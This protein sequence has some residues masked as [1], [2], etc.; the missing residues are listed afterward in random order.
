[1]SRGGLGGE[2]PARVGAAVCGEGA[3]GGDHV[4][5]PRAHGVQGAG[6]P[7]APIRTRSA[8][9][10]ALQGMAVRVVRGGD[11]GYRRGRGGMFVYT[12]VPSDSSFL[13]VSVGSGVPFAVV[14]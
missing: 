1:G 2:R 7:A 9:W 4:R 12:T 10:L 8:R 13:K 6:D 5:A 14:P 3:A 11:A